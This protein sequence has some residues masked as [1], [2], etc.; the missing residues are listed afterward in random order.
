MG[1]EGRKEEEGP[2]ERWEKKEG[3]ERGGGCCGRRRRRS[4]TEGG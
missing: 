3:W 4:K 2:W 1:W